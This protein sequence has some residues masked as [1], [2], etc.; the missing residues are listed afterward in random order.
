MRLW[1]RLLFRLKQIGTGWRLQYT[2]GLP[3]EEAGLCEDQWQR[4]DGA[5]KAVVSPSSLKRVSA[6]PYEANG[7]RFLGTEIPPGIHAVYR[8]RGANEKEWLRGLDRRD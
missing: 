8:A 1:Y 6:A 3:M 2:T 7:E 5:S 4:L